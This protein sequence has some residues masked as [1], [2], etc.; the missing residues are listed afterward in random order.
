MVRHCVERRERK[1]PGDDLYPI[2]DGDGRR[3]HGR[4]QGLGRWR[5]REPPPSV[6][7]ALSGEWR[8]AMRLGG[9]ESEKRETEIDYTLRPRVGSLN[10]S[11]SR[12]EQW[13]K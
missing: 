12:Q 8:M 13:R 10:L 1:K 2:S 7:S 11:L 9:V 6:S 4:R 3:L 5:G